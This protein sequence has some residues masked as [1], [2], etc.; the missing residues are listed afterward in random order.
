MASDHPSLSSLEQLAG[1]SD[2]GDRA[3]AASILR[4]RAHAFEQGRVA[5][6][7]ERVR[8]AASEQHAALRARIRNGTLDRRAFVAELLAAPLELRDHLVEEIL[9]VAYPPLA[10]WQLPGDAVPY[11]PSGLTEILFALETTELAPQQTFVDLGS[12]LGKVVLLVA[13]LSGATAYGVEI[14]PRLVAGARAAAVVLGL[15]NAHFVEAD[16]R[17][18][19]LPAAD[20]YYMFSPVLR[21]TE[22]ARRL[23]PRATEGSF[24]LLAPALDLQ[25]LPWLAA[26]T[27]ESYWLKVY[28]S[29][30]ARKSDASS[31]LLAKT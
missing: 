25:A 18:S 6:L 27:G 1:S 2:I 12:G 11:S 13:L 29:R 5:E 9:E 16:I 23:A 10:D 21:S 26:C 3:F 31:L 30:E 24:T 22:I 28:E 17:V 4:L 19:E 8:A 14:D 7:Y 15:Q 20:V